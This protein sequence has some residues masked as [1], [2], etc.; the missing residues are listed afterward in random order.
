MPGVNFLE[1]TVNIFSAFIFHFN[2]FNENPYVRR[3]PIFRHR[4][5]EIDTNVHMK[6]SAKVISISEKHL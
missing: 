3:S 5:Y 1:I 6:Y 4:P 2:T